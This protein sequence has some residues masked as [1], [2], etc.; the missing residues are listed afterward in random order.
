MVV[1]V[2]QK[3]HLIDLPRTRKI[4]YKHALNNGYV[5]EL[6]MGAVI[7]S[8]CLSERV[9][10]SHHQLPVK[11]HRRRKPSRGETD[12]TFPVREGTV[13]GKRSLPIPCYID[14]FNHMHHRTLSGLMLVYL[15]FLYLALV[16]Y[17][18]IQK[19]NKEEK[20]TAVHCNWDRGQNLASRC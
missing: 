14:R 7:I 3:S 8:V 2:A 6:Y 19:C 9:L 17:V 12:I 16:P 11:T 4:I 18:V 5:Y 13:V 1:V 10:D 15:G 20:S